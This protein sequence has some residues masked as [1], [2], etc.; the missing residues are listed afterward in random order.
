MVMPI[1]SLIP[2]VLRKTKV[3]LGPATVQEENIA[4]FPPIRAVLLSSKE[5]TFGEGDNARFFGSQMH[6]DSQLA[7]TAVE[8]V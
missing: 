1:E 4:S 3:S 7:A 5:I 8:V 6:L 2:V